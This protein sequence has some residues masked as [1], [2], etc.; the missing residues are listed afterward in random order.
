[1]I[2]ES[3]LWLAF[4]IAIV[5][6]CVSILTLVGGRCV[7]SLPTR[8]AVLVA[9]MV[10][11]LLTPLA[12]TVGW[13]GNWGCIPEFAILDSADRPDVVEKVTRNEL[14]LDS[15]Q[16]EVAGQHSSFD[17][18][19]LVSIESPTRNLNQS[20]HLPDDEFVAG[21]PP[22]V[23]QSQLSQPATNERMHSEM[24]TIAASKSVAPTFKMSKLVSVLPFVGQGLLAIW[25]TVALLIASLRIRQWVR[26]RRLIMSGIE[27]KDPSLTQLIVDNAARLGMKHPPKTY[28][29]P[30]APFP[31]VVGFLK[32]SLIVPMSFSEANSKKPFELM[33][34]HE[35]SH[36]R[37]KD[38]WTLLLQV[39]VGITFWWNPFIRLIGL[40]VSRVRE[41]ICDDVAIQ[42]GGS[43]RDYAQTM[44]SIAETTLGRSS[45]P[46]ASSLAMSAGDL[47]Q[48]VE[49]I[50]SNEGKTVSTQTSRPTLIAIAMMA[51]LC[52]LAMVFAQVSAS[53]G[54]EEAR[55]SQESKPVEMLSEVAVVQPIRQDEAPE[56]K[57]IDKADG[58]LRE[59]RGVVLDINGNPAVNATVQVV[60]V[61]SRIVGEVQTDAKGGFRFAC[62]PSLKMVSIVRYPK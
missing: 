32:P 18:K 30:A 50:L 17:Q 13:I 37:R 24:P 15:A 51:S 10:G 6:I 34:I 8:H 48:R 9:G 60:A 12:V 25:A 46:G 31:F 58:P 7:R 44:V 1:M 49:R 56:I 42:S 61:L 53:V 43:W 59:V 41:L 19:N 40:Q 26:C 47:E 54:E 57:N 38:H 45:I 20:R 14:A 2:N 21:P 28:E 22:R 5:S 62:N 4:N 29:S 36:I 52:A 39:M 35:L 23:V 16:A 55:V 3:I 33:L 27:L 11:C